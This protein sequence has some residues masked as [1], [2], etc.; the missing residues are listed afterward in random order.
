[1]DISLISPEIPSGGD[2]IRLQ[3]DFNKANTP[4]NL[5]IN[6]VYTL[7]VKKKNCIVLYFFF[8]VNSHIATEEKVK[9][10]EVE[11]TRLNAT[12]PR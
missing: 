7:E 5:I 12:R 8:P 11:T 1:M 9:L 2:N 6:L 10:I 3:C 4:K